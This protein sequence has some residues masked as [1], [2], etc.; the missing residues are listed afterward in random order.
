MNY[1]ALFSVQCC[2]SIVDIVK[3]HNNIINSSVKFFYVYRMTTT[4]PNEYGI[5]EEVIELCPGKASSLSLSTSPK[6]PYYT[7]AHTF[8]NDTPL[9]SFTKNDTTAPD[10]AYNKEN[11]FVPPVLA[12]WLRP[13]QRE[14]VSFMYECVMGLRDFSGAG[15]ILADDMGLGK[16]CA[17]SLPF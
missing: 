14:G 2:V 15:C 4:K 5:D 10:A 12:K 1:V 8:M 7:H 3:T 9:L 6:F 11:V 16:V 13:H 17:V